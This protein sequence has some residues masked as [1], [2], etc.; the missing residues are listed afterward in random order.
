MIDAASQEPPSA[1]SRLPASILKNLPAMNGSWSR[2]KSIESGKKALRR[3]RN[4]AG[5]DGEAIREYS[6]LVL[7]FMKESETKAEYI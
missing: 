3:A 1:T 4:A 6:E 2:D 7:H 5:E